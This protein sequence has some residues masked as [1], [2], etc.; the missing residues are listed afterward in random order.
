MKAELIRLVDWPGRPGLI[1]DKF[2]PDIRPITRNRYRL[3]ETYRITAGDEEGIDTIV[4]PAGTKSDGA[5]VPRAVWSISG[6]R[7]DGL[8]RVAALIHDWLCANKGINGR[9]SSEQSHRLFYLLM[10]H[11]GISKR[12]CQV[13]YWAVK[14]FGPKW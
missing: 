10:R 13:A 12:R 5:S 4:V 9:F 6:I 7:P 11:A 3:Q 14:V 2:Q 8:I 1:L